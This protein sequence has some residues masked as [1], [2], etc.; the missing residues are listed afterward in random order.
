MSFED[1]L[2]GAIDQSELPEGDK[3]DLRELMTS[4]LTAG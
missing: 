1:Y 3:N 4:H 2:R